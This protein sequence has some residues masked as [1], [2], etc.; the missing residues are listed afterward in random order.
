MKNLIVRKL[1]SAWVYVYTFV[2]WGLIASLIGAAGGIVGWF[3]AFEIKLANQLNNEN[4]WMV[5]F[6]PLGGVLIVGLYRLFRLPHDPGTNCVIESIRTGKPVPWALSPLIFFSTII[7]HLFGGSAG[8]EGAALQL[9]GS[10]GSIFARILRLDSNDMHMA[11]LCG[12]SAVFS[13][14]FGT[15]ITAAFFAMEVISVGVTYY[16]A[17]V[18]CL[19]SSLVSFTIS[20]AFGGEALKFNIVSHIPQLDFFC[21]GRV[22]ALAAVCAVMS[23]VFCVSMHK[24]AQWFKKLFKND[25]VRIIFGGMVIVALTFLLGTRDYNG[26]GSN[27]IARAISGNA[28]PEAFAL[29]IVFTVFTISTGYKGGEIVPTL[30]IGST[31]GCVLGGLLG[32]D[33]CFGAALGM[34]CLFCGVVNC[35]VAAFVMSIEIFGAEG[36]IYF[37]VGVAVSYMLSGYYGLYSSQKIMYSKLKTEFI[38]MNAK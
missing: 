2:R 8:R 4:W 18:P 10:F 34:I 1:R 26:T 13:S 30:F 27:I 25:F 22:I 33:P 38:D 21:I 3:F 9:G 23:I 24:S 32:L 20:L 15:P 7:T 29:K 37:A 6:L 16:A 5:L 17:L 14:L 11:V 31:L 28:K 36:I 19:I 12:M 35:P